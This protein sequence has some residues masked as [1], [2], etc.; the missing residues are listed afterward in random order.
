MTT[1]EFSGATKELEGGDGEFFDEI[2]ARY[3]LL[4]R[5]LSLG[6]DGRWRRRAVQALELNGGEEI[7]DLATGTGDLAIEI[8]GSRS[9]ITVVGVDPSREMIAVGEDKVRRAGLEDAVTLEFGDGQNLRFDDDHFD[10]CAIAFGIRNFPDRLQGLRE[11]SRVVRSGGKVAILELSEPRK[12]VMAGMSRLYVHQ[13]VPRVGALLS[14]SE[15]YKYLQESIAAFPP[16]EEFATMMEEAG[17]EDV[18]VHPLT[19]GVVNLFV[20]RVGM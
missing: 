5:I 15:Q 1:E 11:M 6:L 9:E 10:H 16:A 7:L 20:G 3:D 8:A 4:N 19:F 14:G 17:L 12:G 13:V 2:A 18:T